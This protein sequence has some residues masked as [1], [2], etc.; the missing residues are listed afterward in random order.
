MQK[1]YDVV[2]NKLGLVVEG[3]KVLVTDSNGSVASIYSN[4]TAT[5]IPQTNPMTTDALGRFSFYAADGRY[6]LKVTIDGVDYGEVRDILLNDPADPSAEKIDGGIITNSQVNDSEINDS[7]LT[8]VTIDG[9]APATLDVN[10]KIP[11]A[12]L[13][14]VALTDTFTVSSQAA[15]LALD[16]QPGDVAIRSDLSKSF[17][18]MASPAST[19]SNWVEM[20]NDAYVRLNPQVRESVRRSYAEAGYTMVSG[21]FEAGGTVATATDVLLYEA[22][23]KAYTRTGTL[24]FTATAGSTPDAN[25]TDRS[26]ETLLAHLADVNSTTLI[27]GQTAKRV[28]EAAQ[29][30][31]GPVKL[32]QGSASNLLIRDVTPGNATRV[33]QEPNGRIPSGTTSKYDWMYDPYEQLGTADYRIFNI[34]NEVGNL[35]NLRGENGRTV[36]NIKGAGKQ[37]GVWPSFHFGFQDGTK[38]PLKMFYFDT[39]DTAWRTPQRGLW[40][41]G[42]AY[43]VGDYVLSE[44]KLY[45]ATTAGTSGG[46][47]PIHTSGSVSDGVV[48]WLFVRDYQAAVN[49]IEACLLFG[50]V[51]DMP[52]LGHPGISAQ[53]HRHILHKNGFRQKWLKADGSLL[54]WSGARV[55]SDSYQVEMADGSSMQV[56]EGWRRAN[57]SALALGAQVVNNNL[58]AVDVATKE[59]ITFS[60]TA[61]TTITSFTNARA[62]QSFYV[63]ATNSNTTI[64]HNAAIRLKGAANINLTVETILH[65]VRHSDGRFIQI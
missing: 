1:Y 20:L 19:L 14:S 43:S 58:A 40:Y 38:V 26:G 7:A 16:A 65:F 50:Q 35:P 33:H 22:D 34:Y 8:N 63:E 27:G 59:M 30:L 10:G 11:V 2:Q 64:A 41:S 48:T 17:I 52:L 24:P 55:G 9:K 15:M 61:P 49:A 12:N 6:N 31:F 62:N 44:F 45:Q 39:S 18:L 53:F 47:P 23:G 32:Q 51:D 5:P 36:L 46:L 37:W 57:S 21:S 13:P 28:A 56:F 29:G 3:A 4:N 60:N 42:T 25:W 54:A